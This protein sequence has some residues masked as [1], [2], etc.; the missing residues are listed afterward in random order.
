MTGVGTLREGPL[1]RSLKEW[2][3]RDGDQLEVDVEGYIVDVVRDNQLIEIQTGSFSKIGPKL[4]A[5]LGT[6]GVRVVH[7]VTLSRHI[8]RVDQD[9]V[10]LSRRRSPKKGGYND[11]F[12]ELT[13]WPRL[14][15]DP[16]FAVELVA[17][18]VDEVRVR[19]GRRAWR[20]HGWVVSERRLQEVVGTRVLESP[21]DLV[22]LMPADLPDPFTT[23][24]VADAWGRERRLA[25]QALYCL[26]TL[27]LV[28]VT[29]RAGN[30]RRYS[31][32]GVDARHDLSEG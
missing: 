11:V 25:Q 26:R 18:H 10:L 32:T 21:A 20:R 22:A 5:L 15:A 17:V 30:A 9:G 12:A 2:Y 4:D 13:A 6:H 24:D 23:A 16:S 28:Q 29:G 8:L 19:D 7:P 1:H 3:R 31:Y 14:L 27:G